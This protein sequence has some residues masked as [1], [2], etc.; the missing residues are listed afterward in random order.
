MHHFC[1][2]FDSRY[3]PRGLVLYESLKRHGGEFD[4]LVLCLD[5]ATYDVLH[6]LALPE[7]RLLQ[8][9]ELEGRD[10]ELHACKAARSPIE[11]YFT[12][13]SCLA[14]YALERLREGEVIT[15]LDSDLAFFSSIEPL[16]DELGRN[17]IAIFEHRYSPAI[18]A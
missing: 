17:S 8:L 12:A 3:L 9:A 15:Y 5:E 18:R 11:Y 7:I 16:F 2:Y 1:T 4:L 14:L 6:R 13:T 10:R